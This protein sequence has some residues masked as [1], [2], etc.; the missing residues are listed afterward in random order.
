MDPTTIAV[1]VVS[2]NFRTC[3]AAL[4]PVSTEAICSPPRVPGLRHHP[5]DVSLGRRGRHS[6]G[7]G[8]ARGLA[9]HDR[10]HLPAGG[11]AVSVQNGG[12][13]HRFSIEMMTFRLPG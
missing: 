1:S 12:R 2:G 11:P 6:T 9:G 13:Q 7:D 10:P 3:A 4:V 5:G 8:G